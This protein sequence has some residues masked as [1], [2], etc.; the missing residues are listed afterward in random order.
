[1]VS[2]FF[3]STATVRYLCLLI[4]FPCNASGDEIE[5]RLRHDS[6]E[7]NYS[8]CITMSEKSAYGIPTGRKDFLT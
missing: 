8:A 3:C 7:H 5:V 6:E 4:R 2:H 1:M